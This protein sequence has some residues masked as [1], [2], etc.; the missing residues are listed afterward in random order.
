M[1]LSLIQIN[2]TFGPKSPKSPLYLGVGEWFT[3][4]YGAEHT[5][6]LYMKNS[7]LK[8]FGLGGKSVV[9]LRRVC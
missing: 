7:K 9:S 5:V 3:P 1:R 2:L 8:K 4:R 6:Y